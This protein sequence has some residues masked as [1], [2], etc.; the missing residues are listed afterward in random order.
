[1]GQVVRPVVGVVG[2]PVL[3][4]YSQAIG[5]TTTGATTV[6]RAI[7]PAVH[8]SGTGVVRRTAEGVTVNG[9]GGT[10]RFSLTVPALSAL[11]AGNEYFTP[12]FKK[13][14]FSTVIIHLTGTPS[15][16]S[17]GANNT[18]ASQN[19][20]SLLERLQQQSSPSKPVAN[21]LNNNHH[22]QLHAIKP[23]LNTSN[24]NLNVQSINLTGIQGAVA[25]LPTL[26]SIQVVI[27]FSYIL[28]E[29]ITIHT[30]FGY[31]F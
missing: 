3:P 14:T 31:N 2:A 18:T 23:G 11:L 27:Y 25:N 15:A 26:Q 29:A 17:P 10:Q 5:Q 20:P 24:N 21:A 7:R 16:D 6:V 8:P 30:S 12:F 28:S 19:L 22:H 13:V 9:S 4:S 1:M